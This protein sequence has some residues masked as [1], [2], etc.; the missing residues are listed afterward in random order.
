MFLKN[1]E[2]LLIDIFTGRV[3][4][5]RSYNAGLHQAIQ[6]KERVKIDPENQILASLLMCET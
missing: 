2:I 4:E 6:A 1:D 3:L 5:G